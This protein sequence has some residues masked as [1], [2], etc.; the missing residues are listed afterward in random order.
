MLKLD[1]S[2]A[3][4]P[5]H[6]DLLKKALGTILSDRSGSAFNKIP[7]R[8]HLFEQS[9]KLASEL[10]SLYTH[11]VIIGIGGSSMGARAINEITDSENIFFL[12]NVDAAEFHL[13]YSKIS[14]VRK[15]TAFIAISKSGS[16]IEVLW[17]LSTLHHAFQK[18]HQF[19]IIQ[20]SYFMS[21]LNDNPLAQF[22]RKH[23][24]PLLEVPIDIGGRFSVL[25]PVGLV[26]ATLCNL[27][28]N[29]MKIGATQALKSQ[30]TIIK[31]SDLFLQSFD[32][33]ENITLFWFYNSKYRWFGAWLQQL[34]AESLGKQT[35]RDQQPAPA[36]STPVIAI[37]SCDQHS[38]LQQVAH[39]PKDKFVCIFDFKTVNTSQIKVEK[40]LFDEINFMNNRQYAEL[41]SCQSRATHQALK[42]NKVST[43]LITCDDTDKSENLG[44]MFMFFQL[45]VATIGESQNINSFDQPGVAL[46]KEITL[47]M[48]K[49]L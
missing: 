30:E 35:T 17:N 14:P 41:I 21:E 6:H 1:P 18:D 38:I 42:Q 23:Q 16:T 22:A 31:I 33:H 27:D 19:D 5:I 13:I 3:Y 40:V 34:W 25:T 15:K 43:Q 2:A 8:S 28:I 36:F 9:L 32:R 37:G 46:G 49:Q 45:V 26:I 7:E 12:D 11:F 29:K 4:T 10:K 44:Y 20:N 39:G 47:Q 24:R 48:L